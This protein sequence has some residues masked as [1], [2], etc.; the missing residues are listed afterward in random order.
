MPY[1]KLHEFDIHG[2][3]NWGAYVR[4]VEQ[5]VILN[6]I[7]PELKVATLVTHVG[8][9]TYELMCDLSSPDY[10]ENKEF[11][12]LVEL[13]RDHLEPKRSEIA[14]R[15][16]FRQR[17]QAESESVGVFLQNLKHLA[18]YCKF[19]TLLEENIRDQFVSGLRSEEMRSRLFAEPT[20]DYK[21][22]VE[23]ALALEAAERHAETASSSSIA[24]V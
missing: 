21:K 20:L 7:G 1:G 16:I 5:F 23:L 11:S 8:P 6:D 14:E 2:R 15:H 3:A 18:T 17:R 4:L 22:A 9:A 12:L 24:V 10:P 19:G 13:V